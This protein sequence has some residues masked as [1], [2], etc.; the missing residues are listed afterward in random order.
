MLQQVF[1]LSVATKAEFLCYRKDVDNSLTDTGAAAGSMRIGSVDPVSDFNEL[2]RSGLV[3]KGIS[4]S[5]LF[6]KN[7]VD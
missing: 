4:C 2:L 3:K 6:W 5:P 7:C 1:K